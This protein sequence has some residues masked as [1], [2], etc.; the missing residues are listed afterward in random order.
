MA[1]RID[2]EGKLGKKPQTQ[3]IYAACTRG[4]SLIFSSCDNKLISLLL[5]A[6]SINC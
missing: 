3:N 4:K 5:R 2:E 1:V 6:V